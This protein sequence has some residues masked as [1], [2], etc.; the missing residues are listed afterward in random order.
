LVLQAPA[1]FLPVLA[2]LVVKGAMGVPRVRIS[3]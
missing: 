3:P 1:L 2:A